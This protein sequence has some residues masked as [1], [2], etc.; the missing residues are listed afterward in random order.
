MA[1]QAVIHIA[2]MRHAVNLATETMGEKELA[3]IL[4]FHRKVRAGEE[5]PVDEEDPLA[6][7]WNLWSAPFKP[8][9]LNTVV[10]LVETAQIIAVLFVNYKGRP[11]MK[12]VMENHALFLSLFLCFGGIGFL[13]WGVVPEINGAMHLAPFPDDSFRWQVITLVTA[14]FFGTLIWDRIVV[15]IC[16]P[17]IGQTMLNEAK[18]TRITDLLP[19]FTSLAKVIG[20]LAVVG[21]GNPLLWAMC[22]YLY[23]KLK[24][25]GQEK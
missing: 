23:R 11:W 17:Q 7:F 15:M 21:S 13:A 22:F 14:S 8:N 9:L 25:A 3:S 20:G 6:S 19:I 5:V 1:G 16:A 10:F 12:G 4:A 24:S 2:C 18:N